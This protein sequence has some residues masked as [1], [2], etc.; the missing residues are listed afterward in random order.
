[1]VRNQT[2]PDIWQERFPK[3]SEE[4]V[5]GKSSLI[6]PR[7]SSPIRKSPIN[8]RRLLVTLVPVQGRL[9]PLEAPLS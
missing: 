5:E 2:Q 6:S 4:H 8:S 7:R 9:M 3:V 1:M